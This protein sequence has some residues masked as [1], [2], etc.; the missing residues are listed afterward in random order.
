MKLSRG[1]FERLAVEQIDL[2]YRVARRMVRDATKAEDLVQETYLRALKARDG[3]DLQDCGIKPWLLRIL[4]N[5]HLSKGERESRQ[6]VSMEDEQLQIAAGAGITTSTLPID[7]KSFEGMDQHLVRAIESLPPEYAQVMLL[8]AV[9]DLAYKEIA[10]ALEIPIGT[11]M[12][13]L[14]RARQRLHE[15]LADYAV[16]EGLIR[17]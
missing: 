7:P 17:K 12:S 13:R 9:E 3:F 11:V 10:E 15:L 14:H 5:L 4:Y 8:W 2:L 1:E 6:P 16:E